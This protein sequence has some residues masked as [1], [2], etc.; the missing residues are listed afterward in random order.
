MVT[1]SMPGRLPGAAAS[2]APAAESRA[3]RRLAAA[4]HLP[5]F[6]PSSLPLSFLSSLPSSLPLFLSPLL[7]FLPPRRAGPGR[8]GAA[9]A[10]APPSPVGRRGLLRRG[11]PGAAGGAERGDGHGAGSRPG[12]GSHRPRTPL[13]PAPLSR[14]WPQP[15]ATA[16]GDG[17]RRQGA[18]PGAGRRGRGRGPCRSLRASCHKRSP[19]AQPPSAPR[20]AGPGSAGVGGKTTSQREE[21]RPGV[22]GPLRDSA[23][24][25]R[26]EVEREGCVAPSEVGASP[27]RCTIFCIS[28]SGIGYQGAPREL[29]ISLSAFAV[30]FGEEGVEAGAEQDK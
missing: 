8:A 16:P 21:R 29:R 14:G 24:S 2:S 9:A 6:L 4:P 30:I 5:C 20:T 19:G 12:R 25:G 10:A 15:S 3:T 27:L 1:F 28:S 18:T 17:P 13:S 11:G 26:P 22:E 23:G 7:L